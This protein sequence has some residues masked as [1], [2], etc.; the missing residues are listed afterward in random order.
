[1][2]DL[3]TKPV[4]LDS[5]ADDPDFAHITAEDHTESEMRAALR[6]GMALP[7]LCGIEMVPR[8]HSSKNRPVCPTCEELAGG[9][10]IMPRDLE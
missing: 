2:S 6:D 3:L 4:R 1:M 7:T 9:R 8:P 10:E 5:G